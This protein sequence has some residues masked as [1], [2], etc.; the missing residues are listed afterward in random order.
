L[1]WQNPEA[2]SPE[3]RSVVDR[4]MQS[5]FIAWT[6]EIQRLIHYYTNSLSIAGPQ[7]RTLY[8]SG[9]GSLHPG[10]QDILSEYLNFEIRFLNP[11]RQCQSDDSFF[12]PGYLDSLGPQFAVAAGLALRGIM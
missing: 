9:G 8:L 6:E 11:W 4:E 7:P 10:L 2:L 1:K 3:V 5:A 12:D